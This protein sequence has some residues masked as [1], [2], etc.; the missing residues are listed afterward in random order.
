MRGDISVKN[1]KECVLFE[2][3]ECGF[4]LKVSWSCKFAIQMS[5]AS[6]S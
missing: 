6:L 4:T 1:S 2:L 3:V 5:G